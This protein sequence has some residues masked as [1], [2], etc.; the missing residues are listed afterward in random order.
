MC[1]RDSIGGLTCVFFFGVCVLGEDIQGWLKGRWYPDGLADLPI[2]L[3]QPD[4][5]HIFHA[6]K[7]TVPL[8]HPSGSATAFNTGVVLLLIVPTLISRCCI[9]AGTTTTASVGMPVGVLRAEPTTAVS[10]SYTHL[11]LPTKRI[12]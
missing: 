5:S 6:L 11:T 4:A 3:K 1:I 2:F 7:T 9:P 10:V 12:V 8:Q